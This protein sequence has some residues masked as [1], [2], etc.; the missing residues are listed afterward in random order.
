MGWE[1]LVTS[2]LAVRWLVQLLE[3]VLGIMVPDG[4]IVL[5]ARLTLLLL[6]LSLVLLLLHLL[7]LGQ[8]VAQLH[9]QQLKLGWT[10]ISPVHLVVG[11]LFAHVHLEGFLR[12]EDVVQLRG[13][14]A[15][16][17]QLYF[18]SSQLLVTSHHYPPPSP[19]P[20]QARTLLGVLL[21]FAQREL[22]GA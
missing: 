20:R 12:A 1:V 15:D 22:V 18:A 6:P 7:L 17:V 4:L 8:L 19:L 3:L 9:S 2:V 5:H 13:L 11:H 10:F 16:G 14:V 21:Q